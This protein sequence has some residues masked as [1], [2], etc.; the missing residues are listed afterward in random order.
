LHGFA[1]AVCWFVNSL[2]SS[3]HDA[4][5]TPRVLEVAGV[6]SLPGGKQMLL[7][8]IL[9]EIAKLTESAIFVP[10]DMWLQPQGLT[11][12]QR[13]PLIIIIIMLPNQAIASTAA[14][15]APEVQCYGGAQWAP[16][17]TGDSCA[18]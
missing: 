17:A 4:V 1:R 9:G 13:E 11:P 3:A 8:S 16:C 6:A 15:G 7:N 12:Q 2:L 14:A 18:G 5:F 10:A